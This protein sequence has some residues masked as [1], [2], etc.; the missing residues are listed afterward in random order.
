MDQKEK[1]LTPQDKVYFQAAK[2][3]EIVSRLSTE[4]VR[5]I[6]RSQIPE[7]QI[8]R[9]RRVLTWKPLDKA[10]DQT[11]PLTGEISQVTHKPKARLVILGFEDP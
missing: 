8:L 4:T 6:A 5:K 2:T 10:I 11:D 3:K 1:M 7:D 9:S